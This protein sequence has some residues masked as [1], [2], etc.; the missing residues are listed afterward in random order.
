MAELTILRDGDA[1]LSALDGRRVAIIGFGA[2]GR[3]QALCMRESGVDIIVGVRAGAS[4]D[5]ARSEGFPTMSVGEASRIADIIHILLPDE[6]HGEVFRREIAPA[7]KPGATLSFSHSFSIVFKELVPPAGCDVILVAP[8][9]IATAV[10]ERYLAGSG[11]AGLIAVEQDRSGHARR[12]ALALAKA[13]GYTR[14]GVIECTM[15]EEACG[16]IFGEQNVLCGGMVDLMKYGFEVLTE[17][18]YPPEVAYFEC[19]HEVKLIVDLVYSKGIAKMNEVIS[20]TAEW[21]EYVNGPRIISPDVKE[22][23]KES[24]R[25]I[26]SG[27]FAASL[28]A[29]VRSGGRNLA[30]KREELR[31][32]PA[33]KAGERVRSLFG[34]R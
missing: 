2:Q 27:R 1:D 3:A 28:L 15:K 21:G 10:R 6:I 29:E 16:D 11:V 4:F 23:M 5:A 13:M 20:N 30:A 17:A 26:E 31:R 9:G 25:E 14:S 33:E 24:L 7:M 18:G 12:D 34:I 22:R 32:H 8:K 19:I